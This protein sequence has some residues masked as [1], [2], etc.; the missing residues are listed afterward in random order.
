MNLN[1]IFFVFF[2]PLWFNDFYVVFGL[3]IIPPQFNDFLWR[4][5]IFLIFLQAKN[6]TN[7]GKNPY[8]IDIWAKELFALEFNIGD[9]TGLGTINAD[10]AT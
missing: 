4:C 6:K 9:V 1:D 7:N 3:P 5:F 2:S 10:F 8:L